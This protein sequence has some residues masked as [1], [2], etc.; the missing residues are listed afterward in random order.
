MR[1]FLLLLLLALG[2]A[3]PLRTEYFV[4]R[5]Y[6]VTVQFTEEG[7]ADF[8]EEIAVEIT[9]PPQWYRSGLHSRGAMADWSSFSD[10]FRSD[11]DQIDSVFTSSPSSSSSGGGSGGGGGGKLVECGVAS[12]LDQDDKPGALSKIIS[13]N[14]SITNPKI[15]FYQGF[16]LIHL[17]PPIFFVFSR[18]QSTLSAHVQKNEKLGIKIHS[19]FR[20]IHACDHYSGG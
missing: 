9:E 10:S 5:D 15:G 4:T 2:A 14:L 12:A 20:R 16:V 7:Y 18:C 17:Y 6:R 11:I 13:Y 19:C 3:L 1:R 8:T